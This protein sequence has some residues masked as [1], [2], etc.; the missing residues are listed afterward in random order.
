MRRG[1]PYL[2]AID[3]PSAVRFCRLGLSRKQI[4]TGIGFAHA[5]G[6]AN[7]AAADTRDDIHLDS[8]AGV[9]QKHRAALAVSEK[10]TPC[11]RVGDAL[12]L[13]HDITFQKAAFVAA[14]F[15]GP[16]HADPATFAD[17]VAEFRNV[18]VLALRL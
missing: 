17:P 3:E 18:A 11:R 15:F 6:K 7:L 13:G 1:G 16:G 12:F 9:T 4:G 5:N 10:E 8:F 14:I 2:G